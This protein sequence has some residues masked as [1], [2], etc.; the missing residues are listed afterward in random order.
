MGWV[1]QGP[2]ENSEEDSDQSGGAAATARRWG[3]GEQGIGE[4]FVEGEQ[5]FD[6]LPVAGEGFRAVAAL[7]GAVEALMGFEEFGWHE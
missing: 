1:R 6:S 7:D 3:C 4:F 5:K 2:V